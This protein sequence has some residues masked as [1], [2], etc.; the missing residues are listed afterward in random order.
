MTVWKEPT[1]F[2]RGVPPKGQSSQALATDG[3]DRS[4]P[5][6]VDAVA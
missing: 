2:G 5:L 1:R 6:G 4:M 3:G